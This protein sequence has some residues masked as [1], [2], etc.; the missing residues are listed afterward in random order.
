MQRYAF[1]FLLSLVVFNSC[2]EE[3]T[4]TQAPD[5][6]I[7]TPEVHQEFSSG[8]SIHFF[9]QV[10]DDKALKSYAFRIMESYNNQLIDTVEY[11]SEELTGKR[12]DIYADY[13]YTVEADKYYEFRI[14][15]SDK[16]KNTTEKTRNFHVNLPAQKDHFKSTSVAP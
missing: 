10:R 6:V 16:F 4:D 1:L 2:E 9:V 8:D 14:T 15:V 11:H 5:V 12:S 13:V 7:V 3:E